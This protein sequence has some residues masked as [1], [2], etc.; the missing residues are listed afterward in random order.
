MFEKLKQ[1]NR[2]RAEPLSKGSIALFLQGGESTEFTGYVSLD[3]NENVRMCVHSIADT[4]SNMTIML[5]KNGEYGDTRIYDELSKKIDIYPSPNMTRKQFV[6]SI[7]QEMAI[8]GNAIVLPH[9]SGGLIAELEIIP[10]GKY[11]FIPNGSSYRIRINGKIYEPDEVLHFSFIPSRQYPWRGIGYSEIVMGM[12]KNIAQAQHTKAQFLKSN[13]KPGLIISVNTD[14][15]ELTDPALRK[16]ILSSYAQDSSA[17]EPW[18]IPAGDI[19]VK[20]VQPLSLKDLAIEESITL[21]LKTLAAC[22]GVP[23]FMVGLGEFKTERYNNF[24]STTIMSVALIIQQE[25]TRK[26]LYAPDRYFKLNSR[27]LMQYSLTEKMSFV[28]EAI[29]SGMMTR[30]EGR[31]EFDYSP[32]DAEGMND[33]ITLENYLKLSDLTKQKKLVQ[34]GENNNE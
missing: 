31:N 16:K 32:V 1:K 12:L 17:G 9:I 18:L 19:D 22:M 20:T 13:W 34:G 24:I 27:S 6:Y 28:K 10:Y 23:D 29:N 21:D 25:L 33:H 4:V 7:V 8:N 2:A 26:L 11:C 3:R 14:I 15:D 30:N 5:M